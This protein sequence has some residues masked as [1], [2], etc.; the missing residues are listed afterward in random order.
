MSVLTTQLAKYMIIT[1]ELPGGVATL[2]VVA[3][4]YTRTARS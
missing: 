4:S 3:I 2:T 1:L